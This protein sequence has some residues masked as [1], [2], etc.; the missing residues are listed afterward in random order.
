MHS[1]NTNIDFVINELDERKEFIFTNITSDCKIN[2]L[3]DLPGTCGADN[4]VI[5]GNQIG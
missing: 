3:D 1:I 5:G 4:V 2:T